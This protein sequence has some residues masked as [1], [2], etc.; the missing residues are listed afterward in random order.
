MTL[1]P[2][3]TLFR[4]EIKLRNVL[5]VPS[6]KLNLVSVSKMTKENGVSVIF[7]DD[8]CV[9]T[10]E[11]THREKQLKRIGLVEHVRGLYQL[12]FAESEVFDYKKA[13]AISQDE[14]TAHIT[15][16]LW[17]YRLGHPSSS[18]L[19]LLV[20]DFPEMQASKVEHCNVCHEAKQK[21]KS[22]SLSNTTSMFPFE[23]IHCDLWGP[24]SDRKSVV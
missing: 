6:F 21:R 15:S 23:L 19:D 12:K 7:T 1:F 22:F 18:R 17:H 4:S 14:G 24:F 2:Y 13:Y 3:T 8:D 10:Q 11:T 20:R 5:C 16:H 9:I